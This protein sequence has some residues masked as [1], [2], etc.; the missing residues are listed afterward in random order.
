MADQNGIFIGKGKAPVHLLP[1]MANRHGLIAGAT[2]TGKTVTVRALAEGLS[3]AGV[4]SVV[5]D[6][7]GDL[8]GLAAPGT[9]RPGFLERA[10]AV[11]LPGYEPVTLPVIF[12]DVFGAQ[13]HPMR[14]TISDM[15]PL[16][17]SRLLELSDVQEGVLDVAFKLA[18]DEGLLLLDLKDLRA[19]MG[20][21][22][23]QARSLSVSYGQV[24]KAS[25]GAIQRALLRLEQQGGA[26]FFGDPA[27]ALT[28]FMLT[29]P[30]GRGAI[31]ILAADR[32][33]TSPRVYATVLLWLM[34][35]L[36]EEL[37]E[38]GDLDR[39]KLVFFFDEAHLL[40]D[41]APKALVD[42]IA[43]VVR[44]IRSKGVGIYFISQNPLD[45]PEVVLGQ[46][47]NRIQHALRAFTPRDQAAVRAAAETFRP[48]PGLDTAQAI[49]AL[50]VGEALASC[51]DAKGI[52]QPVER[53]LI[54]PPYT[55]LAPLSPDERKRVIAASPIGTRY[56]TPLDR[57]SAY[58]LL[59]GRAA[60]Q[61]PAA[62]KAPAA[63]GWQSPW[64][65]TSRPE[66]PPPATQRTAPSSVPRST[67]GPAP[68]PRP[69]PVERAKGPPAPPRPRAS[70]RQSLGEAVTKSVL[71]SVG[72]SVGR[73]IGQ[74]IVRGVLGTILRG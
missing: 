4:P 27:T 69:A 41:D 10:R 54:R 34:S 40:F 63:S 50:G 51:L 44:L 23:E 31:N 39:P 35:E 37:P 72:S 43:Q 3:L 45:L 24:S 25:I 58:E 68:E 48:Q 64:G 7:K 47:G 73:A 14:G 38:V 42:K 57:E 8:S 49:T 20:Y 62:D 61:A 12:W 22:A 29:D 46:L 16:I 53:T 19:L 36:F 65:G 71:R 2:G 32:L 18:D 9:A 21:V 55:Q 17:L 33:M 11:G 13:G 67:R 28:D 15:G 6:V 26:G 74:K 56:D 60:G 66:T 30:Q 52:P 1:R 5:A 70:Q 59:Q